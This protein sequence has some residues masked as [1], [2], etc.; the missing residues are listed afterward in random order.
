MTTDYHD[1]VSINTTKE[2]RRKMNIGDIWENS[3]KCKECG[4]KIRSK[5]RHNFVTCQ[6]GNVSCDGGSWYLK[7]AFKSPDCYEETSILFND[8]KENNEK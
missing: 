3:V 6:C 2:E 1:F 7:R 8:V 4:E 5:N